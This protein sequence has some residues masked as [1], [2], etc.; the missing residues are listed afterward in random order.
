MAKAAQ[1][2]VNRSRPSQDLIGRVSEELGIGIVAI[3]EPN[4]IAENAKWLV[5]TDSPPS[6]AI[7][8]QWGDS[9]TPCSP[10][11]RGLRFAAVDWGN[12]TVVSCYFPPNLNNAEFIRDIR[13]L[14]IKL[15]DERGRPFIVMGDFNA[16]APAWDP[17][18][19][20]RRGRIL[21]NW[22]GHV[23]FQLLNV[24]TEPTCV[25]P[26]GAS[27]VDITISIGDRKDLGM[28]CGGGVGVIVG[29]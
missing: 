9:R 8:W 19:S 10:R 24:G 28:A 3:S 17:G 1:I 25:H 29:S 4:H 26:R 15:L 21:I 5:S 13:E 14:E 2:N 20:N 6:A 11:W 27:C 16:R 23:V 12:V 18:Q 7:T 22:M